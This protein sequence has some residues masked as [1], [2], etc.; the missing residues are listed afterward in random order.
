[1][2]LRLDELAELTDSKR[3]HEV[4]KTARGGKQV[5]VEYDSWGDC[6]A[7]TARSAWGRGARGMPS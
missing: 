3:R 1:M 2:R 5:F 4:S 6:N 7:G